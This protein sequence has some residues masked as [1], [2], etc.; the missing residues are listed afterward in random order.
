MKKMFKKLCSLL[1]VT[2]GNG[3]IVAVLVAVGMAVTAGYMAVRHIGEAA[4]TTGE[5]QGKSIKALPGG[6]GS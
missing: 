1:R 5:S 4:K 2:D 6:G 3:E